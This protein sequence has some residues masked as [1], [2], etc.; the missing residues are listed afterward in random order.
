MYRDYTKFVNFLMIEIYAAIFQRRLSPVLPE[1]WDLSQ[2]STEKRTGD[3]F[4]SEYGT[5]IRLYGFTQSP[6]M[7]PSFLTP[8]VFS[9]EFTRQKL[10]I[11]IEHFLKYNKSTDI[12]YPW[13]VG[14][15]TIKNKGA[16]P[17][18][19]GLLRE[20][21]FETEPAINYYPHQVISN[22]R[23]DQKINPYKHGEVV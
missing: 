2:A 11:E 17:M 16:F 1:M 10:F 5:V 19:E 18:V 21:G 9:M 12:K 14:P 7:L 4:M 8:R 23:K 13:V 22:R 15:F 3:F 20:L 6:Y